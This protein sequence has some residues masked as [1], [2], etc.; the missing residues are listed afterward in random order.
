MYRK[1]LDLA[2]I[3]WD[4]LA[5]SFPLGPVGAPSATLHSWQLSWHLT[6]GSGETQAAMGRR[7]DCIQASMAGQYSMKI[8]REW[9][10]L[11]VASYRGANATPTALNPSGQPAPRTSYQ[12][13]SL[14][15]THFAFA[16]LTRRSAHVNTQQP[17]IS[18]DTGDRGYRKP[19]P[20]S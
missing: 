14:T 17:P 6:L 3:I 9:Y 11:T 10:G 16:F 18:C 19:L 15:Y 8:H 7:N 12:P 5:D 4:Q 13:L 20:F 2:M 1:P